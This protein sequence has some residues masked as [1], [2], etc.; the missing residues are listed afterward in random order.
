[1]RNN[2]IMKTLSVYISSSLLNII[3]GIVA[4]PIMT[5][6]FRPNEFG[7]LS[8]FNTCTNMFL[9][10]CLLG[11]DQG[12]LRYFYEENKNKERL[13][14]KI[15]KISIVIFFFLTLITVYY[16]NKLNIYIFGEEDTWLFYLF[17][18]N[19]IIQIFLRY[20]FTYL[21]VNKYNS[22]YSIIQFLNKSFVYVYIFGI[23]YLNKSFDSVIIAY[24]LNSLT[25]LVIILFKLKKD[26]KGISSESSVATE[27]VIKYSFPLVFSSFVFWGL[28]SMDKI[29]LVK[30]T[31]MYGTGIYSAAFKLI[32]IFTIFQRMVAVFW[33]PI[34]FENFEKK[35]SKIFQNSFNILI[36]IL[37][38]LFYTLLLSKEIIVIILGNSYIESI[39]VI[40]FLALIPVMHTLS[41]ITVQGINFKKQTK[42]H[43]IIGVIS[44]LINL[45]GNYLLIPKYGP[46]GASVAT[47]FTFVIFFYL[48]TFMSNFYY[49]I[50]YDLT[51]ASIIIVLMI[52]AS[53]FSVINYKN[54][55][56]IILIA[57]FI[58]ISLYIK[59]I[60]ILLVKL[61]ERK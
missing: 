40:P 34:A 19:L 45:I 4:I 58:S 22:L 53:C 57:S 43:I 10:F 38:L 27:E 13:L 17:L 3:V 42:M 56:Y 39:K 37:S 30:Y 2:K 9:I 24:V 52:T 8:M 47:G 60:K 7:Q 32:F 55:F 54:D 18:L 20:A 28:N 31:G 12:Y 44:L 59:E 41:E 15:I 6:V 36:V 5:R 26:F 29:F 46:L 16:K 48:R 33:P 11:L 23:F 1:M 51:K 49:H 61:K 21:R 14:I 50:K 35:N 25:A